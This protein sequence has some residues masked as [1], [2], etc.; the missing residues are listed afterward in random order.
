M[1]YGPAPTGFSGLNFCDLSRAAVISRPA[2]T[3]SI[4]RHVF[5]LNRRIFIQK[6]KHPIGETRAFG[7]QSEVV[8]GRVESRG[9]DL[10]ATEIGERM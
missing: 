5:W 3:M 7:L 4:F 1:A 6:A 8:L 2:D 9:P 10:E